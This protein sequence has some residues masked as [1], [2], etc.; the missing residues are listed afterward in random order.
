MADFGIHKGK[1]ALLQDYYMAKE[2]EIPQ[3]NKAD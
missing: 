3:G 2:W 1:Y